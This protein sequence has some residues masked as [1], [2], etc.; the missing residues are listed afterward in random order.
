VTT[1]ITGPPDRATNHRGAG[2]G[3]A[4]KQGIAKTFPASLALRQNPVARLRIVLME[5]E[6]WNTHSC[7]REPVHFTVKTFWAMSSVSKQNVV[8]TF[9]NVEIVHRRIIVGSAGNGQTI[10]SDNAVVGGKGQGGGQGGGQIGMT[11]VEAV[12]GC[13]QTMASDGAG[14]GSDGQGGGHGGQ[15][16]MGMGEGAGSE[17]GG[18]AASGQ[19]MT[20]GFTAP[21]VVGV[22]LAAAGSAIARRSDPNT[23]STAMVPRV[24]FVFLVMNVNLRFSES[25]RHPDLGGSVLEVNGTNPAADKG[26]AVDL[27]RDGYWP[28]DPA[29][30][31][32]GS[33]GAGLIGPYRT[34]PATSNTPE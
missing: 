13:G 23:A 20:P 22:A 8:P 31:R 28:D 14:V 10:A 12:A 33:G 1:S 2:V 29:R 18:V 15:V 32:A 9:W 19:G 4:P 27:T 26:T 11:L 25:T 7:D 3:L 17:A 16:G 30:G 34:G 6:R 5:F 21:V 24:I